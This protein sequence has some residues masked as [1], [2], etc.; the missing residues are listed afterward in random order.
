MEQGAAVEY[1]NGAIDGGVVGID[2]LNRPRGKA[3][4]SSNRMYVYAGT[5]IIN[6]V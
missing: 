3:E 4:R 1:G 5:I 6:I 2:I